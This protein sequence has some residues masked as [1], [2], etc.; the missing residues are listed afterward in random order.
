MLE[1]RDEIDQDNSADYSDDEYLESRIG[2]V[3]LEWYRKENH[4]GY[5]A[6]GSKVQKLENDTQIEKLLNA[7]ENPNFWRTIRDE[8]N[9]KVHVLTNEQI[10]LIKRIKD[11]TYINDK[12]K[13]TD[14]SYELPQDLFPMSESYLKKA[15]YLPSKHE[16]LRINKIVHALKMGWLKPKSEKVKKDPVLEFF[17]DVDDTWQYQPELKLQLPKLPA[18]RIALPTHE[19]SFNPPKEYLDKEQETPKNL[20]NLESSEDLIKESFERLMSLY[21]A[22][23]VEKKKIHMRPEDL[24]EKLPDINELKP[25]PTRV[26]IKADT[27]FSLITSVSFSHDDLY[28]AVADQFCNVAVYYTLNTRKIWSKKMESE[29]VIDVKFTNSGLLMVVCEEFTS[30]FSMKLNRKQFDQNYQV[31]Q[32]IFERNRAIPSQSQSVEFKFPFFQ[33][34][35][36][37]K[38]NYVIELMRINMLKNKIFS[39]DLHRK[40][41]YIVLV[42]RKDD[43]TRQI[44]VVNIQ[45]CKNTKISIRA[46][47]KIQ[48]CVF[49]PKKPLIFIM[50]ISHIFIFDLQ[51]Q[52]IKKKLISGCKRLSDL[53]LH[54]SGDHVLAGSYDKNL[55]WFDL[56]GKEFAFKKMNVHSLAIRKTVFSPKFNLFASCSDDGNIVV[57][58]AKVDNEGF[59][60]PTIIPLKILKSHKKNSHGLST[61]DIKFQ[62]NKYWLASSGSFGIVNIWG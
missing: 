18:P 55:M 56:D 43:D 12:I 6:E 35:N 10:R 60:Y 27:G 5:T 36:R 59:S 45:K 34:R 54:K 38:R 25:F 61:F 47:S 58:H 15:N 41:E 26:I 49:H 11:K 46:K 2:N 1:K 31:F 3:P 50:T 4:L 13:N 28:F 16:K 57:Q 52:N 8:I 7:E 37:K 51:K 32:T 14:Y 17:K 19:S 24:I 42:S 21:L 23:R 39:A 30:F 62:F 20:R 53:S 48:K 33:S 44:D 22:P 40:E 29:G 9:G